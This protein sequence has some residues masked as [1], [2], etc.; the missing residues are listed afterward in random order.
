[1]AAWEEAPLVSSAPIGKAAWESAPL[2]GAASQTPT[3]AETP[4]LQQKTTDWRENVAAGATALPRAI[5]NI[6]SKV[7][8]APWLKSE[9]DIL[10]KNADKNSGAYMAGS[11][12]DPAAAAI[13]S[14]AF[15]AASKIPA[16]GNYLRNIVGGVGSGATIGGLS[17]DGSAGSG[18]AIGGG[19]SAA[20][21]PLGFVGKKVWDTGRNLVSGAQGQAQ[22]YFADIF[23]NQAERGKEAARLLRLNSGV[24]G[25]RPTVGLAAVSGGE[26][27]PAYKALEEGARSRQT[28]ATAFA[29]RDAA[30]EA[31]R[32]TPFRAIMAP[33][34]RV[35]AKQGMPVNKSMVEA[36]RG[37]ITKPL[38]NE[39]G[40]EIIPVDNQLLTVLGGAEI[41]PA[42]RRAGVSLDQAIAN[43]N[44]T[45]RTPPAGY[46]QPKTT[47]A[48]EGTPYWAQNP[49][50]APTVEPGTISINAL[51][52]I[53]NEI[54][55]DISALSGTSDSAGVTKL[56]QLRTARSQLD[57]WMRGKSEKWG[58]AQDA[59]KD[60]SVPQ[61]QA[62][63]AAVLLKSLQSPSGVERAAAFGNAF[64]NAPRTLNSAGV[65][66]GEE[67]G[68]VFSPTQMKWANA[69]KASTDRE[70]QYAAL[71]APQT[72][73]PEVKN[74]VD[75][76]KDASP[77]WLNV[78]MTAFHKVMAKVGGKMDANSQ[79]IV[80]S[81]MLDPPKLAAFIQQATPAER[82]VI[83]Q[84]IASI[85][86][87]VPTA[88]IV[89]ATQQKGN[90]D[91]K[92]LAAQL[93]K[94]P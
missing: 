59:F 54:D 65:P 60:L 53:K 85:S 28:M 73:L 6:P 20:L 26:V 1:M 55:K 38:Y 19:I 81:L 52:R 42:A 30:N 31:A 75:A 22:N 3:A 76:I 44:A 10:G 7:F 74:A 23:G 48:P 29:A 62:D 70:G 66:I 2:V 71:K 17:E 16:I 46:T 15:N 45:G 36:V 33:G 64:R 90:S 94:Q 39:A 93:R 50:P 83:S 9:L 87:G 63:V 18:A 34:S 32:A 72:I 88:A 11:L 25:E 77:N 43:A 35:P 82:D 13:G 12:A 14:G 61:N 47:P 92:A 37:N 86:K 56:S 68:Q 41:Q 67:L 89:S 58:Q 80:D 84:Y 21:G 91:Q 27:N 24:S 78:G 49:A 8:D 5:A 69:V 57:G 79:V 4:A 51:Q 40:R